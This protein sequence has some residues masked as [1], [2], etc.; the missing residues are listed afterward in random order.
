MIYVLAM[1]R[2]KANT[3]LWDWIISSVFN[4][5]KHADRNKLVGISEIPYMKKKRSRL[6]N[7]SY[8]RPKRFN[9]RNSNEVNTIS[10]IET[11]SVQINIVLILFIMMAP[12][13]LDSVAKLKTA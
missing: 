12:S 6:H 11:I 7:D 2:N 3:P 10:M 4:A 9:I 5:F 1:Y 13:C 8:C